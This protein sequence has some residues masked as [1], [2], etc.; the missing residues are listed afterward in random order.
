M[1]FSVVSVV[2]DV[3]QARAEARVEGYLGVDHGASSELEGVEGVNRIRLGIEGASLTAFVGIDTLADLR[4]V[5]L[6]CRGG[7]WHVS[8]IP[9]H[10]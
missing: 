6:I 7:R 5:A 2:I 3:V 9:L 1:H 8:V 10:W 4:C